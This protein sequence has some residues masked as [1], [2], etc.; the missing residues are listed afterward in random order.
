MKN[1]SKPTKKRRVQL[2]GDYELKRLQM[3]ILIVF[4]ILIGGCTGMEKSGAN[5]EAM[6]ELPNTIAAQDEYTRSFLV[7]TDEVSAGHYA[8]KP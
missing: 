7:S 1:T 5:E 4:T 2:K 6:T 3:T 8:F